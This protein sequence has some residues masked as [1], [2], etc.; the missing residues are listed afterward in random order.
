V[1]GFSALKNREKRKKK[2]ENRLRGGPPVAKAENARKGKKKSSGSESKKRETCFE[3]K[4][5]VMNR[6][7]TQGEE[8]TPDWT[9]A[10]R[11][12]AEMAGGGA[13]DWPELG[14]RFKN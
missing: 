2:R 13:L 4:S 9:E 14:C 1:L 10:S 7:G 5:H 11:E 12:G 6:R 8:L 3:A